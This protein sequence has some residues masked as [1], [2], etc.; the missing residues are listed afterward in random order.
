MNTGLSAKYYSIFDNDFS[1]IANDTIQ[2]TKDFY[3]MSEVDRIPEC[4][5]LKEVVKT[6]RYPEVAMDVG[7]EGYVKINLLIDENGEVAKIGGYQGNDVFRDIVMNAVTNLIFLPA[8]KDDK[9]VK[10]WGTIPFH[11]H[12]VVKKKKN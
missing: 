6:M 3:N 8:I 2:N 10:C 4:T 1:K 9:P 5:N 11:F 12:L 7:I